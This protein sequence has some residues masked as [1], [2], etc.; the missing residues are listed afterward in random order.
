MKDCLW[1]S[2]KL[3]NGKSHDQMKR[4][5]DQILHGINDLK[6]D[7]DKVSDLAIT[8]NSKSIPGVA[9]CAVIIVPFRCYPADVERR[10]RITSQRRAMSRLGVIRVSRTRRA[11]RPPRSRRSSGHR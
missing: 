1:K 11:R 5:I 10:P 7:L 9:Q 8:G 4:M 3:K 2:G 6:I